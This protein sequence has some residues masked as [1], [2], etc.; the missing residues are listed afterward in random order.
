MEGIEITE[1]LFFYS[2]VATQ[3]VDVETVNV[4]TN[5]TLSEQEKHFAA[6]ATADLMFGD[7][8]FRSRG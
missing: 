4:F 3:L 6:Y 1:W 7:N 5:E 2:E 8:L